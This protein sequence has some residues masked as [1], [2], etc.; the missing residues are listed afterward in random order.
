MMPRHANA[1]FGVAISISTPAP[2]VGDLPEPRRQLD[3]FWDLIQ[4]CARAGAGSLTPLHG[5]VRYLS[6]DGAVVVTITDR[7]WL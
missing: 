5:G 2:T 1:D 7:R 6:G 4:G 3:L